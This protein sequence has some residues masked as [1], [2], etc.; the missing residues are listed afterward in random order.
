MQ[1]MELFDPALVTT[2]L[3]ASSKVEVFTAM[4]QK[5]VA[6]GVVTHED[7]FIADL[8]ARETSFS[9]GVGHGL[10]IPHGKSDA[11]TRPAYAI[12][13]L[14]SPF[15]WDADDDDPTQLVVMLAIPATEAGTT[16]INLLSTFARA[17]MDDSFRSALIAASSVDDVAA[18]IH[19]TEGE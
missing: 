3:R 17:L 5:F 7:A 1:L 14:A 11:V 18:I 15:L 19:T 8:T 10:A 4:T 16:H 2:G 9:T 12:A 6:L 13:T